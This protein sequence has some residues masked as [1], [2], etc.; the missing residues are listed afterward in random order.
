MNAIF[1]VI[2]I[3]LFIVSL[4]ILVI[5]YSTISKTLKSKGHSASIFSNPVEFIDF[6]II[7]NKEKNR[8]EKR[9]Y[10]I[11]LLLTFFFFMLTL[12][13]AILIF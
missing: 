2:E 10:I 9:D 6:L 5:L 13:L 11:I 3:I 8:K 12:G 7:I 1:N 4:G